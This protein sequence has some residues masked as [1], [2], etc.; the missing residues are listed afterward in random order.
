MNGSFRKYLD[1]KFNLRFI[2]QLLEICKL[3][4]NKFNLVLFLFTNDKLLILLYFQRRVRMILC[5]AN[6]QG[7]QRSSN[8]I[9]LLHEIDGAQLVDVVEAARS[10]GT[11]DKC[12]QFL[13]RECECAICYSMFTLTQVINCEC[14][15]CYIMFTLTLV[16]NC[17]CE[18]GQ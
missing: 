16:I 6:L 17:S 1:N 10:Q 5:E 2:L 15:S 9:T 11:I 18:Y 3:E 8:V 14:A 12:R 13:K 7:W 4:R